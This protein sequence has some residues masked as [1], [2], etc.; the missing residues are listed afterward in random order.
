MDTAVAKSAEAPPDLS[1]RSKPPPKSNLLPAGGG[2][3]CDQHIQHDPSLMQDEVLKHP[4][5]F[6]SR[7]ANKVTKK[8]QAK[9]RKPSGGTQ[10]KQSILS[11]LKKVVNQGI[12]MRDNLLSAKDNKEVG[13]QIQDKVHSKNDELLDQFD[14]FVVHA[15]M[16]KKKKLALELQ[17]P[18]VRKDTCNQ[19][20]PFE[21][22]NLLEPNNEQEESDDDD[23]SNQL[24]NI[25]P[26]DESDEDIS[27]FDDSSNTFIPT[28][29]ELSEERPPEIGMLFDTL[30]ASQRFLNI[31][32]YLHGYG[33]VK[34][35]NYKNKKIT[36]QCCLT[37]KTHAHNLTQR[38]RK[39]SVVQ[40]TQC[41]MNVTVQLKNGQWKFISVNL[42]HNHD[43]LNTPSLTK[44][45]SNHQNMSE[46]DKNLS[47][48]LQDCRVPPRRIMSIFRRLKGSMKVL[49]FNK[50]KIQNL[51]RKEKRDKNT[52]IANALKFVEKLQAKNQGIVMKMDTDEDNTVQ[53]ILWTNA[54]SKMDYA[55]Y[56]DFLS[57]DTTFSTN[58]YNMPFAPFIG[59]NGQGR[60]IVFAWALLKDQTS[61][62]FK[63]ALETFFDVMDGKKP[64]I[65]MTDQDKEIKSAIDDVLSSIWHRFCLWHIMNNCSDKMGGFMAVREGMEDEMK[66]II[67]DSLTIDEFESK[68]K[69]MIVKYD[70]A[71]SKHLPLMW[72]CRTQWVPV[73]FRKVFCPF[74][75]TI[76]RSEGMNSIFKDYVK[77][78]DTLETFLVQY[79]LFQETIIEAE[80]DDRF[81]SIGLEP[82]Y[83]GRNLVERHA[84]K[85]YT[86][87]IFFKFQDEMH[88]STAFGVEVIEENKIYNLKKNFSYKG[89]EF[90]QKEF[91]VHVDRT[92]E[93]FDCICGKFERYGIL[94]CHVL[95]LFTQFDIN[96]IPNHY[97]NKRWTK[98]FRE[99]ELLKHKKKND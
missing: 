23:A 11:N 85:V 86:R 38:K 82:I 95:R 28:G 77:R 96:Q 30:E 12:Q 71:N 60:T 66:K 75:R 3:A 50:K 32:G 61:E 35:W 26:D 47:M 80:N 64:S 29:E 7:S 25:L 21:D 89:Q 34:G 46:E 73:Y 24:A 94:C 6:G 87:G 84:G 93:H 83:W 81:V 4:P 1:I 79:D 65:I 49:S 41:P 5:N 36:F 42:E 54:R 37:R 15:E 43:F 58:K 88:N 63:W 8:S 52:D 72:K 76:G 99:A 70:A 53:S 9:P 59:I 27:D 97:I 55:L 48:I 19:I 13:K 51:K 56:G 20:V 74:I 31:Y 69:N 2:A 39:R 22:G 57:F 45:F 92:K 18:H 98:E 10:E 62:T 16:E 68:W 90:Y 17:S 91:R 33:V 44:F 40:R 67:M 14:Q 78:K